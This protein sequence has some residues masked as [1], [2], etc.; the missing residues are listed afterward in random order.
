VKNQDAPLSPFLLRVTVMICQ[1]VII[2]LAA[3]L[4]SNS[5]EINVE[6]IFCAVLVAIIIGGQQISP[7][8]IKVGD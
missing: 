2:R 1:I 3:G 7:G 6:I 4:I 8:N 5:Q